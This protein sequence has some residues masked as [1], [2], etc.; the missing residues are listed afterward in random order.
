M[1]AISLLLE[2]ADFFL[3]CGVFLFQCYLPDQFEDISTYAI[4]LTFVMVNSSAWLS[5]RC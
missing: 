5:S 1:L 4:C 3:I 2:F